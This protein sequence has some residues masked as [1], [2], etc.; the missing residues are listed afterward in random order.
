M[1]LWSYWE[2]VGSRTEMYPLANSCWKK[3][4]E[5]CPSAILVTPENINDYLPEFKSNSTIKLIPHIAQKV[6]YL[7]CC[8][9]AKYGGIWIDID[10]VVFKNPL[11]LLEPFSAS[12]AEVSLCFGEKDLENK[13]YDYV[14]P[15]L[16]VAK[17]NSRVIEEWKRE[18]ERILNLPDVIA[19]LHRDWSSLGGHALGK[20]ITNVGRDRV[21][22]IPEHTVLWLDNYMDVYS[23]NDTLVDSTKNFMMLML[24]GTFMYKKSIPNDSALFKLLQY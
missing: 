4:K 8:L 3:L 12:H 5:I 19:V 16:V 17:P 14:S 9:L 21:C 6:D 18:C 15:A 24:N 13:K 1:N 22:Q 20:A 23:S 7:R 10:T 11:L 2:N